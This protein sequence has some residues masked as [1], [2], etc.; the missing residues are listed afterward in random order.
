MMVIKAYRLTDYVE[1]IRGR[2]GAG[3]Q[4]EECSIR[5]DIEAFP[6]HYSALLIQTVFSMVAYNIRWRPSLET[7]QKKDP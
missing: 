1:D 2:W 6:G 5:P 7:L 3:Y 4:D